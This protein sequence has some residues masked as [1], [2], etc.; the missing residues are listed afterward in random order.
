MRLF[1]AGC[2][3]KMLRVLQER[4]FERLGSTHTKKVDVRLI[5]A[6]NRNLEQM[7]AAREFR[8][9]LY[10]RLNVF[11][12]RIPPLRERGQDISLLVSY[13][14]QKLARRMKKD[15]DTIP[16]AA[17]K[18]L[19]N[20]DWPGN[21]RELENF[22]E[23]AVLLT[24]GKTLVVPVSELHKSRIQDPT[25]GS[26]LQNKDE[27]ARIVRQIVA[28]MKKGSSNRRSTQERD[29]KVRREIVQILQETRGRVG[30][31]NGAAKRLALNRT[32]LISRM[33]RL[34]IDPKQFY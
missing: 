29:D 22:I 3:P 11:P 23:R 32:T 14:T 21:I 5:A 33:K 20:W 2:Q 6:T 1:L 26:E 12:I 8:S 31:P 9:D 27:I 10:Y 30:G 7:I 17:L 13:F 34:S 15:I 4:E 19:T 18:A 16:A 28:D 24:H 25:R